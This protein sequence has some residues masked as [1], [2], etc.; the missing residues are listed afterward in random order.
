MVQWLLSALQTKI[1]THCIRFD[2]PGLDTYTTTTTSVWKPTI[3][4]AVGSTAITRLPI[5]ITIDRAVGSTVI[6]RLP[7]EK[8]LSDRFSASDQSRVAPLI[9]WGFS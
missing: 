5:E 7:I 1:P 9:L 3:D 6:T 8:L 2:T 4:R